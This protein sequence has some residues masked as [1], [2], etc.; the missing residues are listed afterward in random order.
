[1]P[2]EMTTLCLAFW[3][4]IKVTVPFCILI[5]NYE[6]S[7]FS[8]FSPTLAIVSF[9]F[10]VIFI[11]IKPC[12]IVVL[13]C[14]SL[15]S[16]DAELIFMCLLAICICSLEKCLF[17]FFVSSCVS[18]FSKWYLPFTSSELCCYFWTFTLLYGFYDELILD[19]D[20]LRF[21]M[22]LEFNIG[23]LISTN[24]YEYG[25]IAP[26]SIPALEYLHPS[27]NWEIK[28]LIVYT[29]VISKSLLYPSESTSQITKWSISPFV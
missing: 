20:T 25:I 4:T 6:G 27:Y 8:A 7:N 24:T 22:E 13:I 21:I 1:M 5:S 28:R 10:V 23:K 14:I 2:A 16:S 11:G 29:T 18:I 15:M 9:L 12:L 19:K 17:K 3:G 26:V